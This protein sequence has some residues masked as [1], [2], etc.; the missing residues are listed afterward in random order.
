MC[1]YIHIYIYIY[2][3]IHTYICYYDMYIYI[4]I[5]IYLCPAP[6]TGKRHRGRRSKHLGNKAMT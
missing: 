1:V 6:L 2:T 3:Y 4:Y 5:V